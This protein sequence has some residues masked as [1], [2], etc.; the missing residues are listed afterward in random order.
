MFSIVS[1]TLYT[2]HVAMERTR[3]KVNII[4]TLTRD[5][6]HQPIDSQSSPKRQCFKL[7]VIV[8]VFKKPEAHSASQGNASTA[9]RDQELPPLV[10]VNNV[11][12]CESLKAG[13]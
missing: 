4:T 12:N 1:C 8:G 5:I 9:R 3:F 6:K 7:W 11:Y 10:G 2:L 13:N